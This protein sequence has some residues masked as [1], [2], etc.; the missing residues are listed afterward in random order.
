MSSKHLLHLTLFFLALCLLSDTVVLKEETNEARI[1]DIYEAQERVN[2]GGL[3]KE[4][5]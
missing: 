4:A 5:E 2:Y 3:Q 1:Y